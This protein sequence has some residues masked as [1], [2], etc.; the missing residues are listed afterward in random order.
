LHITEVIGRTVDGRV[1]I[2]S[3][4]RWAGPGF[5]CEITGFATYRAVRR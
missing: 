4:T 2:S 3:L 5:A 1:A